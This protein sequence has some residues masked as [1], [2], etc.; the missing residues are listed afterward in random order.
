MPNPQF[1][2][3]TILPAM[4]EML[5]ASNVMQEAATSEP[6]MGHFDPDN[7]VQATPLV[8]PQANTPTPARDITPDL[9]GA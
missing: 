5:G 6:S 4:Q 9:P 8:E 2:V 3:N 7:C 1:I